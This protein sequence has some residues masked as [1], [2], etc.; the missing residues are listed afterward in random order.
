MLCSWTV[1]LAAYFKIVENAFA[2]VRRWN[3]QDVYCSRSPLCL[4]V[5]C[6]AA[7]QSRRHS[8]FLTAKVLP[9]PR[10]QWILRLGRNSNFCSQPSSSL[11]KG[12]IVQVDCSVLCINFQDVSLMSLFPLSEERLK[13][14]I[15]VLCLYNSLHKG[16]YNLIFL[17]LT[18]CR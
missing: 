7:H 14:N 10:L 4:R 16:V 12:R 3:G 17:L 1:Y 5:V 2:A 8:K 11:Q 15:L 9:F 13:N 18:T 6:V